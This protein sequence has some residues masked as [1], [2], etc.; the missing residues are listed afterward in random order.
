MVVVAM[1]GLI[2]NRGTL[3]AHQHSLFFFP[4][5]RIKESITYIKLTDWLIRKF[6]ITYGLVNPYE[7]YRLRNPYNSY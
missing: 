4:K 5:I 1:V 7:L 3:E 6:Y 2:V